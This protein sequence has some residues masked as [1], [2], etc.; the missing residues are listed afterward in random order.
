[1]ALKLNKVVAPALPDQVG[2]LKSLKPESSVKNMR[3]GGKQH[4]GSSSITY[5]AWVNA[6]VRC[7]NPNCIDYPRYGGRGIT[8]CARWNS[9]PLFLQDMGPRPSVHHTLDRKDVNGNYEPGNCRWATRKEQANNRGS[10][11]YIEFNGL[12]LTLAQWA[13]R[14]NITPPSLRKRLSKWK[15]EEALS[16]VGRASKWR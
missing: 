5:K 2:L 11:R 1:M 4:G 8:F 7:N 14:L 6:R 15:I 16:T 10:S 3:V 13:E 12:R 9:Y